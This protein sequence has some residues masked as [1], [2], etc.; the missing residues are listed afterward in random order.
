M[1]VRDIDIRGG[2]GEIMCWTQPKHRGKG[3]L[4]AALSSVLGQTLRDIEVIVSDDASPD[5]SREIVAQFMAHDP[6]VRL[7]TAPVNQGPAAARNRA[8]EVA[9][10]DWIAIVDSDDAIRPERFETLLIA[11]VRLDYDD[12]AWAEVLAVARR[13][14][15]AEAR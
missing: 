10:G 3:V 2:L 15:A 1:V 14:C 4:P 9:R 6:R 5:E 11:A 8:L 13:A 12:H 7:V